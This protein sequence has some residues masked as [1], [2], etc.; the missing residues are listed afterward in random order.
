MQNS[1]EVKRIKCKHE[2]N[3]LTRFKILTAER[4]FIKPGIQERGTERGEG[5]EHGE[6]SLGF[7]GMFSF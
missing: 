2:K 3:T 6:C 7:R 5:R 4:L 1:V